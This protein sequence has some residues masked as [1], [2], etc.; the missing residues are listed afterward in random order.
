MSEAL[1]QNCHSV[2]GDSDFSNSLQ[3][4][5]VGL[6]AGFCRKYERNSMC[7]GMDPFLQSA[8]NPVVL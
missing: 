8:V 4:P 5:L 3:F 6:T 1:R 7:D 2:Q